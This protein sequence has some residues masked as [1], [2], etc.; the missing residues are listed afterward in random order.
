MFVQ[1]SGSAARCTLGASAPP[2][3]VHGPAHAGTRGPGARAAA[4]E[5]PNARALV[6]KPLFEI[7]KKKYLRFIQK[8]HCRWISRKQYSHSS[9]LQPLPPPPREL[10]AATT[11][12][13]PHRLCSLVHNA[14]V[15]SRDGT[16]ALL[17]N[18]MKKMPTVQHFKFNVP[19]SVDPFPKGIGGVSGLGGVESP[20]NQNPLNTLLT[21]QCLRGTCNVLIR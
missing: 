7:H 18:K 2:H 13:G 12:L 20:T 15:A 4:H 14:V 17:E 1:E 6:C 9:L 5:A 19:N 8:Y 10:V 11:R 3:Q 21:E 16:H